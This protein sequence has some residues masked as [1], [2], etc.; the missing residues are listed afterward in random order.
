MSIN[1]KYNGV[2]PITRTPTTTNQ[3]LIRTQFNKIDKKIVF[4][5]NIHVII[6]EAIVLNSYST[7]NENKTKY[8]NNTTQ[9]AKSNY[10]TKPFLDFSL[11]AKLILII[12][13]Y[14]YNSFLD[15]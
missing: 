12:T 6:Y 9:F 11:N 5:E 3:K 14:S 1:E 7:F 4:R 8:N 10:I 2:L 13:Y 15:I